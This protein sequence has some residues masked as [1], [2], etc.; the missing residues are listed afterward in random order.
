ME[1]D[2]ENTIVVIDENGEEK[3]MEILFTFENEDYGK[4]YLLFFDPEDDEEIYASS[5]DEEG[6]LNIVDDEE[7][8]Q[9]INEV[10][11]AFSDDQESKN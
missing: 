7:E 8:W 10:L 3:E 4:K 1:L 5:Y 11:E 6:N 9:M 2:L